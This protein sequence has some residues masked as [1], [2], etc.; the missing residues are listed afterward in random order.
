M[1]FLVRH[2]AGLPPATHPALPPQFGIYEWHPDGSQKRVLRKSGL[3]LQHWF[4]R[5]P[6]SVAEILRGRRTEAAEPEAK[7]D[8]RP[9][10]R[11][12]EVAAA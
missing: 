3:L 11:A 10:G 12:L 9:M 4:K 8:G 5:L 6:G 7:A 2:A 1:P